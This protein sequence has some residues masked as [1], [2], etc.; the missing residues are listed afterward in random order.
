MEFT[1]L[2]LM[3]STLSVSPQRSQFFTYDT[4][5]LTCDVPANS[6]GWSVRRNT[7][8]QTSEVCMYGWGIP[9]ESSCTI[10]DAYPS[11]TGV[12]WCESP[13]GGCSKPVSIT[14][15]ADTVILESPALPVTE[16]DAVTLRC[17]YKEKRDPKSTSDFNAAFYK[18][19][20]F[21]GTEPAGRMTLPAVSR[22]DEGL[23]MCEHPEHGKSQKS[24]LSVKDRDQGVPTPPPP[25]PTPP[26]PF[27]TLQRLLC[28]ILLFIIYTVIFIVCV[29]LYRRWA[30]AQAEEKRR[31]SDHLM[32]Q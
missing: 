7:T 19:G 12:Y 29:Y 11:D 15:T 16:G 8:H 28:T 17:S 26:P 27:M 1:S 22:R 9:A 2:C 4:I 14:V 6:S 21:I 24:R 13:Q 20:A 5:S 25:P 3:L 30:R 32:P 23:Y 18:D 10:E 31:E